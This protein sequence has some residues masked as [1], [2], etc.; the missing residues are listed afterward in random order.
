[1]QALAGAVKVPHWPLLQYKLIYAPYFFVHECNIPRGAGK[2]QQ[3]PSA[4]GQLHAPSAVPPMPSEAGK[5]PDVFMALISPTL[6]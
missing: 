4:Q 2:Q 5:S 6:L 1:M 3:C